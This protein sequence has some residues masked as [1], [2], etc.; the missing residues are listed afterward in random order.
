MANGLTGVDLARCWISW[1]ILPLSQ[2]SGL[3][4]EYTGS[5]DDPLRHANI[6]LTDEE[7]TEAVNKMLNEPEHICAKT[8]LLPFCA[9]NKPPA[10]NDPFWSKKLPQEKP[11]K[12]DKP[13]RSTRQKT[14][15]VKK[16]A[17]R[18]RTTASS[19][20]APDDD[21]DNPDLEDDVEASHA[22]AAETQ[23]HEA[24]RTTRHSGQVTSHSSSG[25][26]SATQVPPLK[27]VLG[28]KPRPSKKARLDKAAEEDAVPEPGKT[29]DL[30]AAIPE[31]IP[32][33]PPQRDDDLI[34]EE[35][36]IDTSSPVNQPTSP[37]RIEKSTN[38]TKPTDKP[39]APVQTGDAKD[40]EVVITGIGRTEPGNPVALSKHTAKEEF[41][42]FGK[43]KWNVDLATYAALNAQDIH[44]GYLNRLYTSRDYE[45]GLVNMMKDKYEVLNH[46]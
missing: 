7:I 33:D 37:I 12:P 38:S 2:R 5:V 34:A 40:D 41:A 6:Q 30:E 44:S 18:K 32:N 15:V 36:P 22:D 45:A 11:E 8:G 42:V 10:G 29:P 31:D 23:Q 24:R 4:C 46:N 16:T 19:N 17:H 28:A 26:S 14:K 20:P 25:E 9:T 43:G 21:V 27:T 35:R 3:M 13:K 1:S 39:T